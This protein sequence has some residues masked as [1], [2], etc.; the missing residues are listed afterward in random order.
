MPTGGAWIARCLPSTDPGVAATVSDPASTGGYGPV[1]RTPGVNHPASASYQVPHTATV[2]TA[3]AAQGSRV[4]LVKHGALQ[5]R[6]QIENV[7][8]VNGTVEV[9]FSTG[10]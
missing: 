4:H 3:G 2:Q 10:R 1:C 6:A 7:G 9:P 8:I 5:I